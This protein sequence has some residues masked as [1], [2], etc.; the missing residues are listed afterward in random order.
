[1]PTIDSYLMFD[2]TCAEAMRFYEKTLGG[3]L[4][5]QTHE[6]SPIS[7]HVPAGNAQRILHARLTLDDRMLMASDWMA[8][9]KYPGMGGF[10]ISLMYPTVDEAKKVFDAFS[11]G[12]QVTMPFEK[13]FWVE[14]FGMVTDRF[15]VSW[16]VNGEP[17]PM[18]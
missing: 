16:A 9:Q 15:G 2:G 17:I 10:A 7:E 18:H 11:Q 3:K 5:M 8:G 13:T 6:N 1:M 4:E 14:G 12:G